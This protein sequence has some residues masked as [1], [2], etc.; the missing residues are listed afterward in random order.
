MIKMHPSSSKS[1]GIKDHE[2]A[3]PKLTLDE[4]FDSKASVHSSLKLEISLIDTPTPPAK[5]ENV[6]S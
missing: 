6:G 3:L 2:I 1:W 4:Q 5:S